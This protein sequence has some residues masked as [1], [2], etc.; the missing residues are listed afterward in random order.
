MPKR[1]TSV[2]SMPAPVEAVGPVAD[3]LGGHR[4]V[5]RL[6]LVGP[7]LAHPARLAVRE[8][9]QDRARV[10]DPVGVVEV[11]DRDLAVEEHGLLD[12]LQ[13]ER[14]DVEVVVLLRAADAERQVVGSADRPWV[15]HPSL[16]LRIDLPSNVL[17]ARCPP[18]PDL[19]ADIDSMEPDAFAAHLADDVRF[20]FGN[21]DPVDR[22]RRRPRHLGRL[23]RGD[24]R[25]PPRASIEQCEHGA[26]TIV[27]STVTYTRKDGSTIS[28]PVVTIYRGEGELIDDYR[29]F[30]DVAPLFAWPRSRA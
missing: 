28:L 22:P 21:A 8:R 12:A 7:A 27:E 23:L 9:G 18:H 17:S 30:M 19:F 15:G 16:L 11:V 10:A 4:E 1:S 29:I 5:D 2:A 20:R 26:A 24:R 25:R 3:R 13:A 14:A 6:R